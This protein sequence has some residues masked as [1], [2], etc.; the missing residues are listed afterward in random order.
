M[1]KAYL[2]E[3]N[4]YWDPKQNKQSYPDVTE[5]KRKKK[6]KGSVKSHASAIRSVN[7][8]Q[9]AAQLQIEFYVKVIQW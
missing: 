4:Q 9:F 5:P 1:L 7:F 3:Q 8:A 6:R 2:D